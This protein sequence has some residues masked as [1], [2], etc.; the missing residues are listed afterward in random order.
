M[1]CWSNFGSK[2]KIK[3]NANPK[4]KYTTANKYSQFECRASGKKM[5]NFFCFLSNLVK[6]S[7][8][9]VCF[10][11]FHIKLQ[12]WS[13]GNVW[14]SR[15]RSSTTANSQSGGDAFW[16]SLLFASIRWVNVCVCVN[17]INKFNHTTKDGCTHTQWQRL[18]NQYIAEWNDFM[19]LA[20]V[21]DEFT[22]FL[23]F[24]IVTVPFGSLLS[25]QNA[26]YLFDF[27]TNSEKE[28]LFFFL[29]F[30]TL[31]GLVCLL[32]LLL[33]KFTCKQ[34]HRRN[35]SADVIKREIWKCAKMY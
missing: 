12:Q 25:P 1:M 26:T 31:F 23:Y 20:V 6:I 32:L 21:Y 10:A 13:F 29:V 3:F 16:W 30:N 7:R 15:R 11:R 22:F 9:S 33:L 8:F 27:V 4:Q 34:Y 17:L 5:R 14:F 19:I 28:L 18:F 35:H 24:F 2:R